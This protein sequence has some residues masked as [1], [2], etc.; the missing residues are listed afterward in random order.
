MLPMY[1][2]DR[3]R[4]L[5]RDLRD[6]AELA[7]RVREAATHAD[8][9]PEPRERPAAEVTELPILE[10]ACVLCELEREQTSA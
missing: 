2:Q 4:R 7:R 9:A 8:G 1:D 3:I 6:S 5:E 10:D